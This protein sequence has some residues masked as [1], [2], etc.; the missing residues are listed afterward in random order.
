MPSPTYNALGVFG[1]LD[2]VQEAGLV[3]LQKKYHELPKESE[4]YGVFPHLTLSVSYK[5]PVDNLTTYTELLKQ[6]RLLLPLVIKVS[7]VRVVNGGDIA[8]A[9]DITQTKRVREMT[10]SLLPKS[11]IKTDYFTVVREMPRRHHDDVV[12]ALADTKTL[13]FTNFNLCAN[14]VND[15]HIIHSS[16]EL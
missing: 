16:V 7:G 1:R 5:V 6:L 2:P 9:F 13:V 12:Q 8:L 10:S 4:A 11:V 14:L 3:A 15:A